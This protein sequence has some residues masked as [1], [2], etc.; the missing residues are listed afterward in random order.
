MSLTTFKPQ[1]KRQ[2]NVNELSPS[3][4]LS[5]TSLLGSIEEEL[6]IKYYRERYEPMLLIWNSYHGP[7]QNKELLDKD[8]LKFIDSIKPYF[9][10]SILSECNTLIANWKSDSDW[11]DIVPGAI[12]AAK[13]KGKSEP[14]MQDDNILLYKLAGLISGKVT[15][16]IIEE[17]FR[18]LS[19]IHR[20][21]NPIDTRK[22]TH[23]RDSCAVREDVLREMY[24]PTMENLYKLHNC[25]IKNSK[26]VSD[27]IKTPEL[28]KLC[29]SL[30]GSSDEVIIFSGISNVV[31]PDEEIEKFIQE[32]GNIKEMSIRSW[33]FDLRVAIDFSTGTIFMMKTK[34]ICYVGG[35]GWEVEV[36]KPA[37]NWVYKHH[38]VMEIPNFKSGS[39]PF[40]IRFVVIEDM[41]ETSKPNNASMTEREFN[42]FIRGIYTHAK[43]DGKPLKRR[44]T[45]IDGGKNNKKRVHKTKKYKRK[46]QKRKGHK[47]SRRHRSRR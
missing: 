32:K 36:L 20:Y 10:D 29:N 18:E 44:T 31:F 14:Y 30:Y 8:L 26:F 27:L 33:T 15:N 38:F 43:C 28:N 2:S 7:Y 37:G 40:S 6:F 34:K 11:D 3:T 35:N 16:F 41:E 19:R 25:S 22:R 39:P 21:G 1:L 45:V 13:S 12:E 4:D 24:R 23:D 17:L 46:T 9:D 5:P 47:Q 42:K